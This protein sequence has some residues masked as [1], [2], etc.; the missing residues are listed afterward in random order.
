MDEA[1]SFLKGK[2][3]P[4]DESSF[5]HAEAGNDRSKTLETL[6]GMLRFQ[7][8]VNQQDHGKGNR[9]SLEGGDSLFDIVFKY[10]EFVAPQVWHEP[11]RR[12][13]NCHRDDHLIDGDPDPCLR[14][15]WRRWGRRILRLLRVH[16]RQ[17]GR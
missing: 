6:F 1:L 4:S 15:T 16:A 2:I 8:V 5:V 12:I 17:R 9:L 11:S 7:V 10:A 13:F 3:E 14:S